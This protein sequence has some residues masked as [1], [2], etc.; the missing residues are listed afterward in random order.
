MSDAQSIK[1]RLIGA[2][3]I[4]ISFALAWLLLLDHDL[5][6]EQSWKTQVPEQLVIERFDIEEP[7]APT[8]KAQE[9][10]AVSTAV[11]KAPVV[12]SVPAVEKKKAV[13]RTKKTIESKKTTS[14]KYTK[15]DNS[16]KPDAWVLQVASFQDKNKAK[17]LQAKLLKDDFPAYVKEFN[18]PSAKIYRVFVGPK[19]SKDR[20][21]IMAKAI[22][23]KQ[24]LKTL[25]VSYKPGFAE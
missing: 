7:K 16:G 22:E 4:V 3:V 8:I 23:K 10:K 9:V 2:V 6:R 1:Y 24:G 12:E 5:Q 11:E 20:A 14:N 25:L 21:R 17:T 13:S 15:L 19:L 18:L